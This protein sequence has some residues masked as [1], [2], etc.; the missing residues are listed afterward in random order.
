[1]SIERIQ[2]HFRDSAALNLEALDTLA[3]PIAAAV[4]TLFTALA[5]GNKILGCA[6]GPSHATAQHL[7]IALLSGFERKR[8]GLPALALAADNGRASGYGQ[9]DAPEQIFAKQVRA[10]GHAG[11]VLLVL[12]PSGGTAPL[13]TAI[14]EAQERE[15][16][17]VVLTGND[18]SQLT[19]K[20]TDT[21]IHIRVPSQRLARIQEMHLLIIHSLCDGIDAMLLG[22][23]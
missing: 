7:A 20:L 5:N 18:D 4:D 10:F 15:M 11:D 21:D 14:A 3:L 9:D 8:P 17:I 23:D 2:Q 16:M 22:E 19:K 6:E 1:M 12:A 13:L